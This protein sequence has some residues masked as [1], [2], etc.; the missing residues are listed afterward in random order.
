MK[1]VGAIQNKAEAEDIE[2]IVKVFV[3]K[4]RIFNL[5]QNK[6]NKNLKEIKTNEMI[7]STEHTKYKKPFNIV[8]LNYKIN[9]KSSPI[10]N[11][12]GIN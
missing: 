6:K 4:E 9:N 2:N 7:L 11:V 1:I 8:P 12:R 10:F 3:I 5:N